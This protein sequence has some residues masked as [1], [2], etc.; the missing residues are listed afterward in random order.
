MVP[1]WLGWFPH[2]GLASGLPGGGILGPHRR[3]SELDL[4]AG[5]LHSNE[6]P[7]ASAPSSTGS[8]LPIC[9]LLLLVQASVLCS[10][11]A[12]M[13]LPGTPSATHSSPVIFLV[14]SPYKVL[15]LP[16]ALQALPEL[17]TVN[18]SL[19]PP[20]S[21]GSHSLTSDLLEAPCLPLLG[22]SASTAGHHGLTPA[23]APS[24]PSW[25]LA[26]PPAWCSEQGRRGGEGR[27]LPGLRRGWSAGAFGAPAVAGTA[28]RL[29][30]LVRQDLSFPES[31]W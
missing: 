31:V 24:V 26:R 19:P 30:V 8:L 4:G 11:R 5:Y 3:D 13:S 22:A 23:P 18:A 7:L 28:G 15:L 6:P 10:L 1:S 14:G 17:P 9:W 12:F 16:P 29:R 25:G 27:H 21:P 2:W 20:R